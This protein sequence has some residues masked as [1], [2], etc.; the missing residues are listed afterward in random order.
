M[1]EGMFRLGVIVLLAVFVGA[2]I[3]NANRLVE[4]R[5]T[6]AENGRYVQ[7]DQQNDHV[8]FGSSMRSPGPAVFDTRTGTKSR[9]K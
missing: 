9:S 2:F 5:A 6:Q 1:S 3:F 8:I 4:I 7:Y